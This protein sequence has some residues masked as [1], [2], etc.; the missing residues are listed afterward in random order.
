MWHKITKFSVT[1]NK[2]GHGT[3][4]SRHGKRAAHGSCSTPAALMT[5]ESKRYHPAT[6]TSSS[7]WSSRNRS[8]SLDTGRVVELVGRC[9]EQGIRLGPSRIVRG[10]V[11]G[12]SELFVGEAERLAKRQRVYAPLVLGAGTC[13]SAVDEDLAVARIETA[14]SEDSG[15][16]RSHP[17]A[18]VVVHG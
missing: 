7:S 14:V 3:V 6:I 1:V 17:R 18:E 13:A 5:Y 4:V 2:V 15:A 16:Q 12:R 9:D 10:P 11:H 8:A